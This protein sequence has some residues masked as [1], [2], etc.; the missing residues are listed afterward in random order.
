MIIL[1]V[2]SYIWN[3][4]D[5]MKNYVIVKKMNIYDSLPDQNLINTKEL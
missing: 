2:C 3:Y 1:N 5:T 4:D